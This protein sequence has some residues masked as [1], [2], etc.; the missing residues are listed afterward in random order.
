MNEPRNKTNI[1]KGN[2]DY[3][4]FSLRVTWA[5]SNRQKK[6]FSMDFHLERNS[7]RAEWYEEL[8]SKKGWIAF[9][10][11]NGFRWLRHFMKN[12]YHDDKIVAAE[13]YA[14]KIISPQ[15]G[16]PIK[17]YDLHQ[18]RREKKESLEEYSE[19]PIY[20][21]GTQKDPII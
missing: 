18:M 10:D 7:F 2:R 4:L 17:I 1:L 15:N 20:P 9:D 12:M 13:I 11:F 14:L 3:S 5:D 16:R 6:Y 21:Q 8:F 19:I